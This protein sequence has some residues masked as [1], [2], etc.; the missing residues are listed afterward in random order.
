M[1]D[2]CQNQYKFKELNQKLIV[3]LWAFRVSRQNSLSILN[4]CP[5]HFFSPYTSK[6]KKKKLNQHISVVLEN[7]NN[8]KKIISPLK[9]IMIQYLPLYLYYLSQNKDKTLI[10]Q[11]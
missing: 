4:F 8:N 9:C 1:L 3:R 5:F 2:S 11:N 7:N 6:Q 10:S